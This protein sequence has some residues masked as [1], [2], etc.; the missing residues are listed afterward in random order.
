M[1]GEKVALAGNMVNRVIAGGGGHR[2]YA[3]STHL[4][5]FDHYLL[6][7][8]PDVGF[9]LSITILGDADHL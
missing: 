7:V 4:S 9:L 8:N 2:A 1:C 5:L 6:S 3:L